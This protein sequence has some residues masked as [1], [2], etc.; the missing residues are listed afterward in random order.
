MD[1]S[2]E[3]AL[4][5]VSRRMDWRDLAVRGDYSNQHGSYSPFDSTYCCTVETKLGGR[6]RLSKLERN[7]A[8]VDEIKS[9][10]DTLKVEAAQIALRWVLSRG[11]NILTIPGTTKLANLQVNLGATDIELS[12]TQMASL[13]ALA[14]KVQGAR[15]NEQGMASIDG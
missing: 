8:L 2:K 5:E 6:S 3:S 10:A 1:E 7:L 4:A 13:N 11:D 12:E 15:Y 9:I 14:D